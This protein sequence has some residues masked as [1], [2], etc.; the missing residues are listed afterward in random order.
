MSLLQGQ[1]IAI[2]GYGNQGR[3]QKLL[4]NDLRQKMRELFI[5]DVYEGAFVKEWSNEQAGG[6]Q[7]LAELKAKAMTGPMSQAEDNII[8]PVQKAFAL[9]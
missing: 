7:I 2:L 1:T 3:V 9:D 5:K 8:P 4:T 6:S